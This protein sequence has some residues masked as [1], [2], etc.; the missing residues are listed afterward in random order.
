MKI[1][2]YAEVSVDK[3]REEFEAWFLKEM[4]IDI[5]QYRNQDP[6]TNVEWPYDGGNE[7]ASQV[8]TIAYKSWI[9]V[10]EKAGIQSI[11]E[12]HGRTLQ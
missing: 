2:E 5:S 4:E 7:M 6:R 12:L 3:V 10:Y 1:S 8:F 9:A 11:A